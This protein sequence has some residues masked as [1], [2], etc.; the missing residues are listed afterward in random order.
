MQ[1][2]SATRD[3]ETAPRM[4]AADLSGAGRRLHRHRERDDL[5][6]QLV[7]RDEEIAKLKYQLIITNN[8]R[9]RVS[10]EYLELKADR[11]RL[12]AEVQRLETLANERQQEIDDMVTA[13]WNRSKG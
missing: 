12:R 5:R 10:S 2:L 11:D 3:R 6:S 7:Q 4:Y 8:G 1:E 9:E 13:A